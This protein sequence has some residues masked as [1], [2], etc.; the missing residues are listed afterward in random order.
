MDHT[1]ERNMRTIGEMSVTTLLHANLPKS[2]WGYAVLHAINVI[3]RTA[4]NPEANR[5]AGVA[6]SFS[7]LEKWKGHELPGQTK[8]L[9]PF[10]CLAF[11]HIPAKIR[12]SKLDAHAIPTVYLGLDPQCRAF[13]L[14]SL[15]RLDVSTSVEV[16]FIENVFPFRKIKRE[17]PTSLLWG[18]ENNLAEGDGR[19]GMFAD[20]APLDPEFLKAL[21]SLP[22]E[23][24]IDKSETDETELRR[25]GR[26][27]KPP[28]QQTNQ[29][30][31][32]PGQPPA[33]C[34]DCTH[35]NPAANNYSQVRRTSPVLQKCK[36]VARGHESRE[37]LPHQERHLRGN[38]GEA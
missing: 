6:P 11:K 29:R 35:R 16:T 17:S 25:S 1:A 5:Q 9:Y 14:G 30:F 37:T 18:T 32:I 22:E 34:S 28:F 26:V 15:Y 7:R 23:D 12:T 27:T 10:G 36:A 13:L 38:L 2:A 24:K 20:S 19:L 4:D 31:R 3:N 33:G 21:G 8:G